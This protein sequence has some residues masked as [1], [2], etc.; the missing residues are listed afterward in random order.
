MGGRTAEHEISLQSGSI[1]V[2]NL[3]R[4]KYNIKPVKIS[5]GER[6]MIPSGF[7]GSLP[8]SDSVTSFDFIDNQENRYN[9]DISRD[10]WPVPVSSEIEKLK[11]GE[12]AD[13]VFIALHGPYGEDGTV[14]GLLELM[15][16]PYTGSDVLS[17]AL[18]MDKAKCK[19]VY[20]YN[21][22]KVPPFVA[23]NFWEWEKSKDHI[24]EEIE[25]KIGYP[26]IV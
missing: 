15:D 24:L 10:A 8:E 7:V 17:S 5:K 22:I 23:C 3:D 6:W 12:K 14:Q 26:C 19:E 9:L 21:G 1:I 13:V 11:F 25:G 4:N 18:A 16:I 20:I 2:R